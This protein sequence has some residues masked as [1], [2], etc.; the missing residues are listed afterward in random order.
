[1]NYDRA[2]MKREVRLAMKNAR[3]RPRWV[4]LLFMLVVGAGMWLIRTAITVLA[5]VAAGAAAFSGEL[6]ALT[7]SMVEGGDLEVLLEQF[8]ELV[9]SYAP[10]FS[11]IMSAGV[12]ITVL[13]WLWGTLMNAGYV[14]YHLKMVRGTDPGC[15]TLFSGFSRFGKVVFTRLLVVLF[16]FLWSLLAMVIAA[17][18]L[19]SA[20][21]L[22]D[23]VPIA[24]AALVVVFYIF[25]LLFGLWITYRFALV[26][27]LVMD[28]GIYGLEALTV[29]KKLMKGNKW[30]M[31][32][33][34]LSF[35]GWYLLEA[36]LLLICLGG[37]GVAGFL[38]EGGTMGGTIGGVVLTMVML[39]LILVIILLFALFLTPYIAGSVVKLYEYAMSCRPDMF[40]PRDS[41]GPSESEG[42]GHP[43]YP[44]LD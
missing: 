38:I 18:L 2:A 14:G 44:K 31:F 17:V 12:L 4:T 22:V 29:S 28:Q 37:I 33:L 36:A 35:I 15:G 27:H 3:P 21:L 16:T 5:G 30:H 23:S 34:Y 20:G 25:I 10:V 6:S 11:A 24:S 19:V 8:A 32:V 42:F 7:Q 41:G 40:V 26:D 9:V 39:V 43:D 1:M 13:C